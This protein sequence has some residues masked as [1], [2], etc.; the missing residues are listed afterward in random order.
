MELSTD[1]LISLFLSAVFADFPCIQSYIA[2]LQSDVPPVFA[3]KPGL[4]SHVPTGKKN[5]RLEP[6]SL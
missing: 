6:S 1:C 5:I 4:Q 3:D 2:C